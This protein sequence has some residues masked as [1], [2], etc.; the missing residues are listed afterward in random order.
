[1]REV[2]V[3]ERAADPAARH[4]LPGRRAGSRGPVRLVVHRILLPLGK[5]LPV[6]HDVFATL[7]KRFKIPS[8][9][10][11]SKWSQRTY[12]GS[13]APPPVPVVLVART[14]RPLAPAERRPVGARRRPAAARLDLRSPSVDRRGARPGGCRARARPPRGSARRGAAAGHHRLHP[15]PHPR[16]AGPGR[17]GRGFACPAGEAADADARGLHRLRD[18]LARTGVACQ[19]GFQSLGAHALPPSGA[20]RR[21]RYR[22]VTGIGAAGAWRRDAAYY[23]RAPWRAARHRR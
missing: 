9:E 11:L 2:V 5:R 21:R 12:S 6:Q 20:A 19:V 7:M 23:A 15:H 14:A 3:L 22:R 4:G 17:R 18:G 8:C 16:G 1:M 13:I 10:T